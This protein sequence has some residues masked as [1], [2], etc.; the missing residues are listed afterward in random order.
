MTF[1][2]SNISKTSSLLSILQS[3]QSQLDDLTQ[4]LS[5]G[6]K[7]QTLTGYA[8]QGRQFLDLHSSLT[9][10]N[11]YVSSAGTVST[12]LSGYDTSLSDLSNVANQLQQGLQN[13]TSDLTGTMP[14]SFGALVNGLEVE[15]SA[16]LNT[17]VGSRYIFAGTRYGTV[18]VQD[19]ST[20]PAL[21]TPAP[22]AAATSPALADYDT[23]F[24]GPAG[25]VPQAWTQAKATIAPQVTLS[26]GVS[27]NDPSIQQLVFALQNAAA[28]TTAAEPNRSQYLNYARTA[29][30]Q[31]VSG[32]QALQA[33]NAG[34]VNHVTAVTTAQK[35]SVTTLTNMLGGVQNIDSTQVATQISS[36]QTQIQASYKAT[37]TLLNLSIVS[38]LGTTG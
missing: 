6:Q 24:P 12:F 19:I 7:S 23:Q 11:A 13:L 27:S 22:F 18:P 35:Q 15:T 26:Y 17:Q 9:A 4:Q 28:A 10:A 16:T 36:L 30:D 3:N 34:N 32:L 2:I 1:G 8:Q 14:P 5:S 20:L 33:V 25:G 29:V 31:A 37:A 38:Y 21:T